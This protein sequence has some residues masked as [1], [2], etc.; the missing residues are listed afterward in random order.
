MS[1][2][3]TLALKKQHTT[4]GLWVKVSEG[5]RMDHKLASREGQAATVVAGA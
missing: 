1:R 2:A 3:G 5:R 4:H